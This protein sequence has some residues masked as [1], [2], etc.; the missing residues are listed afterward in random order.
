MNNLNE[1]KV[2]AV[3]HFVT[4]ESVSM[5]ILPSRVVNF[6]IWVSVLLGLVNILNYLV[7]GMNS[8]ETGKGIGESS[9]LGGVNMLG[10]GGSVLLDLVCFEGIRVNAMV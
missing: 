5:R 2:A 4:E 6:L 8:Y 7:S 3:Q 10:V 1:L 9:L